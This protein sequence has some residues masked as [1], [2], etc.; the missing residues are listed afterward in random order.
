MRR[1]G[2]D[3]AEVARRLGW[4][5]FGVPAT[6]STEPAAL[7][8]PGMTWFGA[9][10]EGGALVAQ[11]V[12]RDYH[13]CFGGAL[14]P[15]SGIAGVTVVAEAR[16]RGALSPL[17]AATSA[18]ARERGAVISTLFPTAPGIYRR[19]GY[20]LVADYV[21][22]QV[23][24]AALAAV[25]APAATT[26]RRA[27]PDDLEALRAVYDAWALEQNGPL[28]RRG[29]SFDATAAGLFDATGVSLAVDADGVVV[30]FVTWKRGQGYGEAAALEVSD[31]L[32][33]TADGYRALLRLL[34][35]FASVAASTRIDTSGA[36]L[37]R[38]VL[39][40]VAW[41]VQKSSPYMLRVLD[42]AG[43]VTARRYPRSVTASLDLQVAGDPGTEG[44]YRLE[45]RSGTGSCERVDAARAGGRTLSPRGLALLYS[46]V[47]SSANLRSSGHL[48][49]GD[50][51][52]DLDWDALFGGRQL[53]VR[54]YF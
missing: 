25:A 38:L 43:A 2:P 19:F 49:G 54:D 14:V 35:S 23:P 42:V 36:D 13:S 6:P 47:Q 20:E 26:T 8:Q 11:M 32:S 3:D 7:D 44:A 17:F 52:E 10:D 46:G 34:G 31:L 29:V 37:S 33:R 51:A 48:Q 22:V 27:T 41:P 16:G 12:D 45:V 50:A 21:T 53:H 15:T 24:T 1:L 39:P 30:G 18:H 4:E 28:W 40:S 5:A 9:F